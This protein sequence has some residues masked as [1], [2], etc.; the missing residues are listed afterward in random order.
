MVLQ[1]YLVAFGGLSLVLV[2]CA[3]VIIGSEEPVASNDRVIGAGV[4]S[5]QANVVL[6]TPNVEDKEDLADSLPA[7]VVRT[8]P[9]QSVSPSEP[10]TPPPECSTIDDSPPGLVPCHVGAAVTA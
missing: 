3:V 9:A 4:A 6:L 8:P 10:L 5:M 7:A 2:V 1:G